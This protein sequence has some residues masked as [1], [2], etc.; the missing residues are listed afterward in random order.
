MRTVINTIAVILLV[1]SVGMF[2]WG[3]GANFY[4]YGK[5]NDVDGYLVQARV[6]GSA[7]QLECLLNEATTE[8]ERLGMV[9]GQT[10]IIPRRADYDMAVKYQTIKAMQ[11]RANYITQNLELYSLQENQALADLRDALTHFRL[12]GT[13]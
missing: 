8:M 2:L 3:I 13:D 4:A 7:S 6:A 11:K 5:T 10:V 9:Q 1:C 12:M